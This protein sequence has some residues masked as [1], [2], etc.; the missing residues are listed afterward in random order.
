MINL[1]TNFKLKTNTS[2]S[3]GSGGEGHLNDASSSTTSSSSSAF[4]SHHASNESIQ[5]LVDNTTFVVNP[6]IFAS[7]KDTML[8]RMFFST[9]SIARP[10]EKGQYVI[11]GFSAT[12]FGAILVSLRLFIFSSPEFNLFREESINNYDVEEDD[13]QL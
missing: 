2:S 3:C 1:N 6:E 7:K 9:P 12:V 5:L 8:Y 10:N 11:E 4:S 13:Y